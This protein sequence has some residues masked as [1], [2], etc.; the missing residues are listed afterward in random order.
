MFEDKSQELT[1]ISKLGEF[2][3]IKHL[4][5]YF[6][7]SNESSELG[8]GDDA[9]VINPDNKKVVL[10]TDVLAEGVHFNLAMFH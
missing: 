5:Q 1:P 4:T 9:A 8:V 2:G 10:T 3:L 6:P 7:L